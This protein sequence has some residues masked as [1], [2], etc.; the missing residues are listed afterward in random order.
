MGVSG[1]NIYRVYPTSTK[2]KKDK[3]KTFKSLCGGLASWKYGVHI[4]KLM[5]MSTI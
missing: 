4:V 2:Y 5:L 1:T 3:D